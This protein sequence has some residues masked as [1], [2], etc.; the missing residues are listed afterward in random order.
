MRP[1][2]YLQIFAI[3]AIC[4]LGW[5]TANAQYFGRNKVEYEGGRYSIYAVAS[6]KVLSGS[7][8]SNPL[9]E[10]RPAVLPPQDRSGEEWLALKADPN[11]GLPSPDTLKVEP[12]HSKLSLDYIGQPYL[13]VGADR[14]GTYVAGGASLFWSDMLGNDH[15]ATALQATGSLKE[16]AALVGYQNRRHRWNWGAVV[17]QVPYRTGGFSSGL[18]AVSGDTLY[19]EQNYLLRQTNR[20]ISG[21]AAYPFSQ[22]R[23]VEFSV[24]YSRLSF[25]EELKTRA[26]SLLTGLVVIDT[27]MTLPSPKPLNF[28]QTNAAWVYDNSFF[29]ATSPILGKRYRF[30]ISPTL[31]SLSYVGALADYRRYF[32]PVRPFLN[33]AGVALGAGRGRHK[34][35]ANPNHPKRGAKTMRSLTH[36]ILLAGVALLLGARPLPAQTH[37]SQLKALVAD[38]LGR[39]YETPFQ[40]SVEQPAKVIIKG[41]VPT[42]WD[43]LNVFG[44]VARVPGVR[45]I[46]NLLEVDTKMLPDDVI[47]ANIKE[48]LALNRSIEE[49]DKIKVTVNNGEVVL[50]GTVNFRREAT[51][52]EDL[53]SWQ[54]GVRGVTSEIEVLPLRKALSDQDLTATLSD[55]IARFFPLEAK[56]VQVHVQNGQATLT[57]TVTRLWARYEIEKEAKRVRGV[58]SV[59]NRIQVATE[60]SATK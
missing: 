9:S 31:G 55:I 56:S 38:E 36:S 46:S 19:V 29:G 32:M 6:K 24:G 43:K 15:L 13:A 59:D 28:V 7:S 10:L 44:I 1:S 11:F 53:A 40:I 23:R 17:Q 16:I 54:P 57:G 27:T 5:Q 33:A 4:T 39:Y 42:Y 52:A 3:I 8:P 45:E 2:R 12:Y 51:L 14:Y 35:A 20:Q 60:F 34:P 37:A 48:G 22:V 41:T 26:T 25:H 49:P 30:E 21:I 58:L 47:K 50:R 18:E